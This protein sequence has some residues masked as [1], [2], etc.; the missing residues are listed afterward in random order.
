MM[1]IYIY[2]YKQVNIL[3]QGEH[4]KSKGNEHIKSKEKLN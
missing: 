4:N 2:I 1:Y 3:N